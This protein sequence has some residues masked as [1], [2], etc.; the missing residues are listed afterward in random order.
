M[1]E[2]QAPQ[3]RRRLWRV[4]EH[5]KDTK[6]TIQEMAYR[7]MLQDEQANM[8]KLGITKDRRNAC[9]Q[10]YDLSSGIA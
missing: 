1:S 3:E 4:K 7:T 9:D 2:E 5:L 6:S 8:A 10:D